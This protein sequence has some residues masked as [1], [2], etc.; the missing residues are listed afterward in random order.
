MLQL[1]GIVND[2]LQENK[3]QY[4]LYKAGEY[5]TVG[6]NCSV[7]SV[8]RL[9]IGGGWQEHVKLGEMSLEEKSLFEE[10]K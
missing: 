4:M 3:D 2:I 1:V 6:W 8:Q 7:G 9:G 10:C 5:V